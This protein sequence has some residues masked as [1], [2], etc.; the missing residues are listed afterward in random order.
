M[1]KLLDWLR[2]QKGGIDTYTA[3]IGKALEIR[4]T[5]PDLAAAAQLLAGM[6]VHFVQIY[7]GQP[8]PYDVARNAFVRLTN[9]VEQLTHYRTST[10][11]ERLAMLNAIGSI[12]LHCD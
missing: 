9:I 1:D 4:R 8:L 6:A 5:Q 7:D 12:D 2:L 10:P 11:E 3:F